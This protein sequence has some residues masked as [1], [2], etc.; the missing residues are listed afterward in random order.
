MTCCQQP[1]NLL[2]V[3]GITE[4]GIKQAVKLIFQ[5]WITPEKNPI[6]ILLKT[7]TFPEET[8]IVRYATKH[9]VALHDIITGQFNAFS[10]KIFLTFFQRE[11]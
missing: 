5:S 9:H 3:L 6:G 11:W 4:D 10:L 8:E 7:L 2:A 1:D